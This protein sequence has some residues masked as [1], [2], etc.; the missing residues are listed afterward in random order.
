MERGEARK[1]VIDIIRGRGEVPTV[2]DLCG[3]V[4]NLTKSNFYRIFEGGIAEACQ[5][6]GVDVPE[7]RLR[8]TQKA[9]RTR[10][11][12]SLSSSMTPSSNSRPVGESLT[13]L[14]V[15]RLLA[16]SHLEGGLGTG[17]IVDRMLDFD[18]SFRGKGLV[19]DDI[20]EVAG[21]LREIHDHGLEVKTALERLGRL[22]A[23]G[24]LQLSDEGL[25]TMINVTTAL[26]LHGINP[27][28]FVTELKNVKSMTSLFLQY[29]R[30]AL[31]AEQ[32]KQAVVGS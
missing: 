7:G 14:Q 27:F 2:R 10:R 6:A 22:E 28:D 15:N 30:G 31:T 5:L 21:L 4:P 25:D 3:Q 19:L 17:A 24:L 23:I 26:R 16:I 29:K 12:R 11:T 8:V 32:F 20:E 18:T 1:R 9:S 13:A